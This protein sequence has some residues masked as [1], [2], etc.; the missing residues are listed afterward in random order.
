[1]VCMW[2]SQPALCNTQKMLLS[3]LSRICQ[4]G[5]DKVCYTM[6]LSYHLTWRGSSTATIAW[7][8]QVASD[9]CLRLS[10]TMMV[11]PSG[12]K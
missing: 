8:E 4:N 11:P 9:L 6:R 12:I 1:M 5:P 10:R 2:C 3:G 7:Y